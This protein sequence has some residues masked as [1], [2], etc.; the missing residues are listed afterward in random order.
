MFKAG[1]LVS[2][3]YQLDTGNRNH[4][5]RIAM[6]NYTDWVVLCSCSWEIALTVN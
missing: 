1:V 3:N 4:L 2:V 5:G 6:E